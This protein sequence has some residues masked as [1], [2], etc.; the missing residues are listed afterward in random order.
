MYIN[1]KMN[2]TFT[3]WYPNGQKEQ[4]TTYSN[5]RAEGKS[6]VWNEQGEVTSIKFYKNGKE[7]PEPLEGSD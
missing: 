5:D 4:E 2:G 3:E 7:V 6:T 1:D